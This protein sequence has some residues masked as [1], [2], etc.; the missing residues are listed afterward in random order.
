MESETQPTP[1]KTAKLGVPGRRSPRK[2]SKGSTRSSAESPEAQVRNTTKS[3]ASVPAADPDR[4]TP[5]PTGSES[6]SKEVTTNARA[7]PSKPIKKYVS[8]VS[9][10][11]PATEN[12]AIQPKQ[13]RSPKRLQSAG[14]PHGQ[15]TGGNKVSKKRA[16]LLKAINNPLN[17]VQNIKSIQTRA[18]NL[19]S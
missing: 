16:A 18:T 8:T 6:Q 7:T 15:Y 17:S 3:S 4:S 12:K 11:R 10:L 2:R 19:S 1:E 5:G 14:H 13:H 9:Y